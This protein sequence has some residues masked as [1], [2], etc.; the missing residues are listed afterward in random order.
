VTTEG[1]KNIIADA[2]SRL[3]VITIDDE[4]E[5]EHQDLC[6]LD[7]ENDEGGVNRTPSQTRD[8]ESTATNSQI[9]LRKYKILKRVHNKLIGHPRGDETIQSLNNKGEIWEGRRK[10]VHVQ[11]HPVPENNQKKS[12]AIAQPLTLSSENRS[13]ERG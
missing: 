10:N 8:G 3:C 11:S 1:N 5:E 2:F 6:A 12:L 13:F 7:S 4:K 9:P